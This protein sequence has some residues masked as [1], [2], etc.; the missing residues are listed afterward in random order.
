MTAEELHEYITQL[1]RAN[2]DL[3]HIEAK[4]ATNELPKRLWQTLSAFS[5]TRMGGSLLLGIAEESGFGIIGV[6]NSKKIQQ[7]LASLCDTMHPPLRPYIQVHRIQNKDVITAEIPE[8][9]V[10]SKPCFHP[11]AGLT[12]GAFI[13]VADGDRKLTTYEVQM[14]LSARGQ[15]TE[16]EEP[17]AGTTLEELQPRLVRGFLSRLQRRPGSP[18]ARATDE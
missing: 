11:S 7:D 6:K 5:N 17:V 4:L 9:P 15:P 14:M 12:N 8:L 2:S 1:R 3:T 18:F 10:G 13:R 16:D